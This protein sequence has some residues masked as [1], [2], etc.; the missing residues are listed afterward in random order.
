MPEII[1]LGLLVFIYLVYSKTL[2]Y[3][4]RK[5]ENKNEKNCNPKSSNSNK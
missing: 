1:V 2:N 5:R 4:E 3:F